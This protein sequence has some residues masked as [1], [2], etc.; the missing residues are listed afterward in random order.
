M[1]GLGLGDAHR[2]RWYTGVLLGVFL[3]ILLGMGPPWS[4]GI[5]VAVVATV[6]LWEFQFLVF[7]VPLDLPP[8]IVF[9][10]MG[11]IFPAGAFLGAA[12]GLHLALFLAVVS[13]FV[14]FLWRN[15]VDADLVQQLAKFA[16]AWIYIPY[17]LSHVLLIGSMPAGRAWL[18]F[19]LLIIIS[20]DVGAFYG[21]RQW[22]RRKLYERVS[23]KKTWEGLVT[24]LV[25]SAL[26][27]A[28]GGLVLLGDVHPGW[29]VL[30][31]VML[32]MIGQLGDLSESMLKRLCGRKDASN[33]L[34]GH[35][36]LLDRLD[37]LLMTFPVAWYFQQWLAI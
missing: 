20:C 22:G 31:G 24:G 28:V 6:G 1:P 12:A 34:P 36:G 4:W 9:L 15:P 7:P 23:P 26:A 17:F 33:L 16:L 37:S 25:C 30:I 19:T 29:T 35:G 32:G 10:G 18:F 27:G 14:L 8:R 13:G 11:A 21:G 3:A 2:A 5:A